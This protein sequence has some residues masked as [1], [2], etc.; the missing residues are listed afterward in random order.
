MQV[1]IEKIML[2]FDRDSEYR[3]SVSRRRDRIVPEHLAVVGDGIFVWRSAAED[4]R[5]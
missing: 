3:N 5:I 2:F 4:A 1:N